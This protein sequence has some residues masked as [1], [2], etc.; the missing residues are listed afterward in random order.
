VSTSPIT[1]PLQPRPGAFARRERDSAQDSQGGEEA[2]P[3][4]DVG[5]APELWFI[6][7]A[8]IFGGGQRF[9]L[10]LAIAAAAREPAIRCVMVC[11]DASELSLRSRGAGFETHHMEFPPV[12]PPSLQSPVVAL[13]LRRLLAA[14]PRSAIFVANS[15][16]TQAYAAAARLISHG[17]RPI[18][19]VAHE[20]DTA[21]RRLARAALRHGGRLVAIGANTARV[22]ERA[23][24]GIRVR[25]INNVLDDDEL[26]AAGG[27]RARAPRLA[28]LARMIPEKG[29][30][31][32]L[33]EAAAS[34]SHWST[35]AIGAPPQDRAYEG[36]VKRCIDELRLTDRAR[37]FGAISDVP[38]FL[39]SADVL[40]VPSTGCEG[41]PTAIIEALARGLPVLVREPILSDD[42]NGMPVRSYRDAQDFGAALS[43]LRPSLAS[44]EE[45]RRRFGADQ[46][47]DGLLTAAS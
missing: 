8:R 46:A 28:V 30:V 39:D 9:A 14:A 44:V 34:S 4:V 6:D 20:Q 2:G 11:P 5:T 41:Q 35:L 45:M 10:K 12:A 24:P 21:A 33:E 15:P 26:D 37:V 38:G 23:L 40:I 17:M 7:D 1:T 31:E 29:I 25:K 18:V 22:Y 43:A 32:L 3:L 36:R 27:A 47:I 13:L 16:R 42:F 19:N